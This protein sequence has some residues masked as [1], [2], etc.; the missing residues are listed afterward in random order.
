MPESPID[1]TN[2][3]LEH[4]VRRQLLRSLNESE[5]PRTPESLAEQVRQR[6]AHVSYHLRT[7]G[8][9]KLAGVEV[10]KA[11]GRAQR[12]YSSKVKD[13]PA[14]EKILTET[15][16]SDERQLPRKRV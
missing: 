14:V 5:D 10:G 9:T 12:L 11:K 2:G 13:N 15:A 3:A 7:L 1:D 6:L 4:V 8:N 16:E